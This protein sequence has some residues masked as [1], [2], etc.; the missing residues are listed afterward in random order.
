M[1]DS[2]GMAGWLAESTFAA[3]AGIYAQGV[4]E[5]VKALSGYLKSLK[6]KGKYDFPCARGLTRTARPCWLPANTSRRLFVHRRQ[7]DDPTVKSV[8]ASAT[9]PKKTGADR[10]CFHIAWLAG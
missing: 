1:I 4:P 8:A 10:T 2:L 9:N 7:I 6:E 3:L 5:R